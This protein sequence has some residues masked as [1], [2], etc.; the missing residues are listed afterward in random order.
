MNFLRDLRL[1]VRVLRKSPAFTI[2]AL[3]VLTLGI[4]ANTA[5]FSVVNAVLIRPLPYR[6]AGRLMALYESDRDHPAMNVSGPNFRDW[7]A[8]APAF[9][10]MAAYGSYPV[11]MLGGS[12]PDRIIGATVSKGFFRV[13]GARPM[14]GR[15]FT[16]DEE[17]LGGPLTVVIGERVWRRLFH[18]DPHVPGRT[19]RMDGTDWTVI[20]VL[21]A[22]FDFPRLADAWV[23][24]EPL[25]ENTGRDAHN[26]HVIGRLRGG[27]TPEQAQAQMA[28][29]AA[30][31]AKTYPEANRGVTAKV[32]PLQAASA[33]KIAPTLLL[34][35]GAVSFVFLI[36][37]ANVANLLLCRAAA[38]QK[39]FSIRA[40][41]GA[42]RGQLMRQLL[43]EGIALALAAGALSVALA[44][45][46][47]GLLQL[48]VPEK[49]LLAGSI[50]I[51]WRVL[52]FA[53]AVALAA[54][55]AFGLAPAL[56][57]MGADVNDALKRAGARGVASGS[58][59]RFR[60]VLISAEVAI[61][62]VLL[63]GA[64][65]TVKSLA[66]L[67]EVDAGFDPR[68]L[69]IAEMAVS[70]G[71]HLKQPAPLYRELLN[72]VRAFPG[73]EGAALTSAPPLAEMNP[74]GAFEVAGVKLDDP[75]KAPWAFYALVS[76][77]YFHSM[78]IPLRSGRA[79][80]AADVANPNVAVISEGLARRLWPAGN[81]IGRQIRF[82]GFEQKPQ[83]LSII[84]VA[85]DVRQ[86][87]IASPAD[88][89]V[90]VPY[91]QNP[92][93]QAGYLSLVVRAR[94]SEATLDR[95]IRGQVRTLDPDSVLR[96]TSMQ[97]YIAE[98]VATPRLRAVLLSGFAAFALALAAIGLY[99]VIS[100]AVTNR[101]RE[102][103]VRMALGAARSDIVALFVRG[104]LPMIGA[105]IL[106]GGAASLALS[107]VIRSFLYD[108][109]PADPGTLVSMALFL[110]AV[111]LCAGLIPAV[112]AGRTD[113]A[114]ALRE[115]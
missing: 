57:A 76:D 68:N 56:Y 101:I 35:L 21:P 37:C 36:A 92:R 94:G 46:T 84:G 30:R 91:Y 29:I 19:V 87:G 39:E 62:F 1:A 38:R 9:S 3:L 69:T 5:I 47:R 78:R 112:R 59:S 42:G 58:G 7:R 53:L 40:A 74:N 44:L 55:I 63:A 17:R 8:Q 32:E 54:G 27:A 109:S 73:V 79:F 15:T 49:L 81:A 80:E 51:D 12:E 18:G 71:D 24:A 65:L 111:A 45:W 114:V 83:W 25:W 95:E 100:F 52:S 72:R 33:R 115:E 20:G 102:A 104:S 2:T 88:D 93:Y 103:G 77:G 4:G 96:F 50:A 31:I 14:L 61:S 85:G 43:A 23:S 67:R 48:L 99:G 75:R 113:P 16:A 70:P 41:L 82:F 106:A 66:R 26:F 90:Y 13:M 10:G 34:L 28:T 97:K 22:S 108:V 89:Q 11:D 6:D 60:A 107:R 64:G 98:N 110:G 86:I 105:G